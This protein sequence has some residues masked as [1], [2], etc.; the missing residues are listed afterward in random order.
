MTDYEFGDV[1]LIPFPF[2]DQTKSKK[3]PAAYASLA[4]LN[5]ISALCFLPANC[6]DSISVVSVRPSTSP[7]KNKKRLKKESPTASL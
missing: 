5:I 6:R 1:V 7:F 2:T 4:P 3:R